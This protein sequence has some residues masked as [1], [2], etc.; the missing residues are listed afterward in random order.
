MSNLSTW[1]K[2]HNSC[3][4]NESSNILQLSEKVIFEPE[5]EKTLLYFHDTLDNVCQNVQ[6]KVGYCSIKKKHLLINTEL[7]ETYHPPAVRN[8]LPAEPGQQVWPDTTGTGCGAGRSLL[9]T[10]SHWHSIRGRE[11]AIQAFISEW[12]IHNHRLWDKVIGND[13]LIYT[14]YRWPMPI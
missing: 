5:I 2:F 9:Q 13:S 11:T 14:Q 8:W 7:R 10:Q 3:A 1:I 4:W 6:L 12:S